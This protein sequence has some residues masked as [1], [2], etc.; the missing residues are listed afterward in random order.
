MNGYDLDAADL[1]ARFET[2]VRPWLDNERSQRRPE[3][4]DR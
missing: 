1:E 4:L 3:G 2:M